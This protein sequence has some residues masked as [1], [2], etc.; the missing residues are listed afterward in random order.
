MAYG[1]TSHMVRVRACWCKNVCG[2]AYSC[3]CMVNGTFAR[4]AFHAYGVTFKFQLRQL[5]YLLKMLPQVSYVYTHMLVHLKTGCL[6]WQYSSPSD[7]P[8]L[9][10][11]HGDRH[12]EILSHRTTFLSQSD[13]V[14]AAHR[15]GRVLGKEFSHMTSKGMGVTPTCPV[16]IKTAD[17]M[18]AA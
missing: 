5:I 4:A 17:T 13:T 6:R 3:G 14:R 9:Q 10:R 12:T 16:A 11:R 2:S 8:Y 7:S 18:L 15:L 1:V